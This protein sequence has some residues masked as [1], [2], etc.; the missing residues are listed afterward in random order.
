MNVESRMNAGFSQNIQKKNTIIV[1]NPL[2]KIVQNAIILLSKKN[3][4]VGL[5]H[6]TNKEGL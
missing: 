1:Q 2:V 5:P 4:T 6:K 3:W